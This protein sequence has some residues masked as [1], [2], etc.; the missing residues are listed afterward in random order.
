[1]AKIQLEEVFAG[2]HKQVH[3]QLTTAR[4]SI[5]HPVS[6]GDA[7]E[8]AW[9]KLLQ[10]YLPARY[11]AERALVVDSKGE[12]SDVLDVVVFDRQYSPFIFNFN[13]EL[14]IPAEAV[15][16]VF[17]AKQTANAG[18]IEYA[19]EKVTGV[20]RL[21]RTSLPIPH[22]G[23]VYSPKP[24]IPIIGGYLSL[25]SDWMP[26]MGE[27]LHRALR[28]G[29]GDSLLDLGCVAEHGTFQF[30]ET[31]GEYSFTDSDKAAMAFIFELIARLQVSGTV[32]MID[33][34]EYAK[35]LD[36]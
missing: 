24:L 18:Y 8:K 16:A 10:E 19:Q 12:S 20:R 22:A 6:K 5:A 34:R 30:D 32:P 23:G 28:K 14:F 4:T 36:S 9:L 11:R 35:F 31:E 17:E 26:P 15:Y 29:L 27:S 3:S 13:G 21:H 7:S 33:V 25:E 1:M 2:I